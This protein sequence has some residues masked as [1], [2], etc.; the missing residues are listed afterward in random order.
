MTH[1]RDPATPDPVTDN[2]GRNHR[3]AVVRDEPSD[4]VTESAQAWSD[5][6]RA[7]LSAPD[8]YAPYVGAERFGRDGV[9]IH[10]P[11]LVLKATHAE[12]AIR[13]ARHLA[14]PPEA[15]IIAAAT[16]HARRDAAER[17]V[18]DAAMDLHRATVGRDNIGPGRSDEW[19][20]ADRRV[21]EALDRLHEATERVADRG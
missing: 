1:D 3:I 21:T 14:A 9:R 19:L 11:A 8:C 13:F 20:S 4:L 18:L 12:R 2:P 15:E 16:A 6:I 5:I 7:A 17:A 10:L